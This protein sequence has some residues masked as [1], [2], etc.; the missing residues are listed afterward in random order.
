MVNAKR[1]LAETNGR[2]FLT[3]AGIVLEY[4]APHAFIFSMRKYTRKL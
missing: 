3:C 4:E 2:K 1:P